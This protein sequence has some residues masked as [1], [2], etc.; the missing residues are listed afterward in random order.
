MSERCC[1]APSDLDAARA[2]VLDFLDEYTTLNRAAVREQD[3]YTIE[4]GSEKF[5]LKV[6][7]L[8]LIAD[9]SRK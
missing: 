6:A 2:R 9:A 3:V 1:P 7:D 5:E 8:Y 4:R